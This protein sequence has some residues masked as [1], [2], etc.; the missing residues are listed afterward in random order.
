MPNMPRWAKQ[1]GS[2]IL[3]FVVYSMWMNWKV[4]IVFMGGIAF[5]ECGHLYAAKSLGMKTKGFY[6][7]PFM[8]GAALIAERYKKYTHMAI[9]LLAGPIAGG[10]LTAVCYGFYL[11]TG[12]QLL[13]T[14]ALW[15]AGVNLFNLVPLAML[16]GGQLMEAVTYSIN[17]LLGLLYITISYSLGVIG[18]WLITHNPIIV[19]FI[20]F[21]GF[22]RITMAWGEYQK[23]RNGWD[24]LMTPQPEKMNAGNIFLVLSGY[25]ATGVCLFGLLKLLAMHSLKLSYLFQ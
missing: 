17:D 25:V 23:K 19:G 12:N 20:G 18:L 24:H 14:A 22:K 13:G 5:H 4:A 8:G 11:A 3:S 16:D 7:I 2:Y 9:V 10:V 21:M 6:L 15:M 1:V